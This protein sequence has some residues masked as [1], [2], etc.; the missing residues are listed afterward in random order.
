MRME[1]QIKAYYSV[2][3]SFTINFLLSLV[4]TQNTVNKVCLNKTYSKIWTC[5]PLL[6]ICSI[7]NGL[8]E[9]KGLL[10]LLFKFDL[11]YDIRNI[12]YLKNG[13]KQ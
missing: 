7:E 8:K 13:K 5:K 6:D 9:A 1:F 11:E 10:S 2:R 4:S 3:W 12:G